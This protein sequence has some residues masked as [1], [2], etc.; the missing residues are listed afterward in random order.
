MALKRIYCSSC[1]LEIL[2]DDPFIIEKNMDADDAYHGT[3]HL[4]PISWAGIGSDSQDFPT[5]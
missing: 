4:L 5:L 3:L 2:A 1:G